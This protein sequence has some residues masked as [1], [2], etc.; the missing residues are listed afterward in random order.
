MNNMANNIINHTADVG[1]II[2]GSNMKQL[3][4]NAAHSLVG[5]IVEPELISAKKER[6]V[7]VYAEN[8]E[9]LLIEWLNELIYLFDAEHIL[10]GKFKIIHLSS[11]QLIAV[12]YGETVNRFKDSIKREVKA[13]TYH[14]L[15]ID[16]RKRGYR[17]QVIFDL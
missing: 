17:A 9:S 1:L 16:K 6:Y 3:F 7:S 11:G 14:M 10:F 4:S 13:A 2:Y 8:Y 12:C 15:K 5:L